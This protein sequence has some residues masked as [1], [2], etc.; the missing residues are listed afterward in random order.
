[1]RLDI[2]VLIE[3]NLIPM[4]VTCVFI[5]NKIFLFVISNELW[6]IEIKL[7]FD[8]EFSEKLNQL[9]QIYKSNYLLLIYLVLF[10]LKI[11]S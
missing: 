9:F 11:L 2:Y 6:N 8:T 4:I 5:I 1:M 10:L 7:H 3:F